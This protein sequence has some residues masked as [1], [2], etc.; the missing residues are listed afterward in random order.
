MVNLES[1]FREKMVLAQSFCLGNNQ[2]LGC[3]RKVLKGEKASSW[4]VYLNTSILY[5]YFVWEV[6]R[7][8]N[9]GEIGFR[10]FVEACIDADEKAEAVKYIIKLA[11]PREKAEVYYFISLSL[12]KLDMWIWIIMKNICVCS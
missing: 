11:D 3:L 5:F 1:G 2:G 7:I 10:P 6:I 4:Y 8:Y 12:D 9:F